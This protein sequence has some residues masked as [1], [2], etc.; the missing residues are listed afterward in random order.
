ML[1][2]VV[3][4]QILRCCHAGK[5]WL[6]YPTLLQERMTAPSLVLR[7]NDDITLNLQ[8]SSVLAEKLLV[9]TTTEQEYKLDTVNTSGIQERLYH[10]TH[11]QSSVIIQHKN[12]AMH[13]EGVINSRLRIKP[14]PE[15]ER[16]SLGQIQHKLYEVD[17]IKDNFMKTEQKLQRSYWDRYGNWFPPYVVRRT[18]AKPAMN[19]DKFV[20]E[21]HV[22]SD[23]EHQ[24]HFRTNKELIAYLAVMMNAVNLRYLDMSMP[25]ISFIIVGITRSLTDPFARRVQG[26]LEASRTLKALVQYYKEGNIPDNPDAVYLITS[27]DLSSV[28]GGV[29]KKNV[30][31]LAFVGTVCTKHGVAEGEDIATSYDGVYAMAHELAHTL[32]A[33][34][35]VTPKCPWSQGYLMSYADGGTNKYR[36][37]PCSEEQIR[38]TARKLS[39]TCISVLSSTNLMEQHKE[40]PGQKVPEDYYCRQIL[41]E[42]AHQRT[43]IP[44][45]TSE[46]SSKCKMYCCYITGYLRKCQQVDILDGMACAYG[47]T[48]RRGVCGY[49]NWE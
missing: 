21:V 1:G 42:R 5:E 20:V 35:D 15:G 25:K 40:V 18:T 4:L 28:E 3:V 6:V 38:K 39:A 26:T 47:Q 41:K 44:V 10:D 48:C 12:G 33:E 22:I 19:V 34:H 36:L 31:G 11:H 49:H 13:V 23:R 37:S 8:R 29:L 7:L 27:L 14:L 30:A 46:L 9:V 17:E 45:K 32:G 43:V 2:I 16:S 24:K